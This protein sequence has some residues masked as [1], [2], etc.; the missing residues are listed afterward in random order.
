MSLIVRY[1]TTTIHNLKPAKKFRCA[2]CESVFS[3]N[4]WTKTKKGYS[5]SCP[6]CPYRAWTHR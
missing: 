4:D 6:C 3:T 1:S 5:T 2:H